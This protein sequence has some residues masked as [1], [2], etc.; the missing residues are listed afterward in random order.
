MEN[1]KTTDQ[2]Y[3]FREVEVDDLAF[4][5]KGLQL[6]AVRMAWGDPEHELHLLKEDLHNPLMT[7]KLVSFKSLPIA[8]VQDYDI[9]SWPQPHFY[10]LPAGTRSM[11]TF[12]AEV[13]AFGQGHGAN[14][15]RLRA[16]AIMRSGCPCVV[17]DPYSSN[18]RALNA[19]QRAGFVE[20]RRTAVEDGEVVI[21]SYPVL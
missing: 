18:T 4:L 6:P 16:E 10:D 14:Y 9:S 17:I 11:D 21:F 19:Y 13:S 2:Y 1:H 15:L 7:M 3:D 20:I 8:Y 5:Y 12:I